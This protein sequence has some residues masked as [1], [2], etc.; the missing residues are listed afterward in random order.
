MIAT[1]VLI[2]S[3]IPPQ[4]VFART[5]GKLDTLF[6][7]NN[8]VVLSEKKLAVVESSANYKDVLFPKEALDTISLLNDH[9]LFPIEKMKSLALGE[10]TPNYA[11]F[12][13]EYLDY[14]INTKVIS[15]TFSKEN[16]RLY[17]NLIQSY[18][19][20]RNV[21]ESWKQKY[22]LKS[23]MKGI[24]SY[25]SVWNEHQNILNGELLFTIVPLDS[26]NYIAKIKAPM[27]NSGKIQKGQKVNIK[28]L[29]F[30]ATEYGI[31]TAIVESVSSSPNEEGFYIVKVVLNDRL[32]TSYN[33]EIPF[34]NEM[35]GTAEIITKDLRLIERFFIASEIYS[36][37]N[38]SHPEHP[39]MHSLS[40]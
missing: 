18:A 5:N 33:I 37:T 21:V 9:F 25:I 20:L 14:V 15:N 26:K 3:Q 31:L 39:S 16:S 13:K 28:L 24:V 6:V 29:N 23:R 38:P 34:K 35:T 19:Q 7:E 12:K 32:V 17:K 2:T 30:P 4:M 27:R 8:D 10:V 40:T 36:Q 22:V 11:I 1:D